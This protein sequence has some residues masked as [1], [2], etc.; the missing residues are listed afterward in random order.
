MF[1]QRNL[2]FRW[3]LAL[4]FLIF[5]LAAGPA[6]AWEWV[7]GP[8]T[9]FDD[10]FRRITPVPNC[11]PYTAPG[12]IAVGTQDP[13]TTAGN[14]EV[15]VV[16]TNVAGAPI[17]EATYDVEGLGLPDDGMAIVMVP[18]AGYVFLSN[19]WNG[20]WRPALTMIDCKG[21]VLWSRIYPDVLAGV[22][23]RGM[24]L[25]RTQTGDA[26][27][28]TAPGDLAVAGFWTLPGNEDAFLMRT[29]G[30]GVLIWNSSYNVGNREAFNAL[31]EALP[32]APALTGDLVAA[33]RY[34]S[35]AGDQQGLVARVNGNNGAVGAAPQCMQHHGNAGSDEVYNSVVRLVNFFAGQFAFVGTS[36]AP[37]AAGWLDDIWVTRGNTC[38][39]TAQAR[40]GNP[41]GVITS[42]H[43]NDIV[44]VQVAKP[45]TPVGSLAVAGDH[46]PAAG[47][48]YDA[49]LMVINP[50]LVPIAGQHRIFGDFGPNQ[51]VFFSLADDPAGWPLPPGYGLA[52]LT[53]TPWVGADPQ[54]MYLVHEDPAV[55]ACEK[56]WN[57]V[58]TVT[59]WPQVNLTPQRRAP[60]RH[61]LVPTPF[62][63]QLTGVQ[64]CAP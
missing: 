10:A 40:F 30:G 42:E 55:W 15:Y 37:T 43:G 38:A 58:R 20:V 16:Y 26:A 31:T 9:T 59:A 44:E 62:L 47:G 57:P 8:A 61:V 36:T 13:G 39:L 34:T 64:I 35:S 18:G 24:D 3:I 45:G 14:S 28:G 41:G 2:P 23:L 51:E 4:G 12:Y 60:A 50:G 27:F 1:G 7:Y 49:A 25:I 21:N 22:D 46:G 56:P 54:D 17:W 63:Y 53:Q 52:G 32:V 29:N 33:G 48:P 19:S 11:G 6:A 5:L